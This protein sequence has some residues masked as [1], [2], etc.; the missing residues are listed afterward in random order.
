[1]KEAVTHSMKL[2]LVEDDPDA[3]V[4]LKYSLEQNGV[5]VTR[6]PDV[7][8][9]LKL[10][11]VNKYD[12]VVSDI[13]LPKLSGVDLLSRIRAMSPDFPVILLTAYDSLDT[14]IQAV[15]L[16]AQD[17]ILKPLGTIDD[18]LIPVA[19][20]VEMYRM[21][22][23]SKELER[24]LRDSEERFR[25]LVESSSDHIFMLNTDG[26]VM[27]SNNR[28]K[29]LPGSSQ[30][31]MENYSI[32]DIV[33]AENSEICKVHLRNVVMTGVPEIFVLRRVLS[34]EE[35]YY[36]NILYPIR[37]DNAVVAAGGISR[38]ITDIKKHEIELSRSRNEL[39][40]MGAMLVKISEKERREYAQDI[41]DQI[42]QNVTSLAVLLEL[43]R[44]QSG[45]SLSER[46][47][48]VIRKA[49]AQVEEIGKHVDSI[50]AL[51]KPVVID[52]YGLISALREHART[53]AEVQN[54]DVQVKGDDA[55]PR[56]PIDVEVAVFRIAQEAL[57]N[58]GKH[59]KA[60]HVLISL[61]EKKES[62]VL[63]VSD[64]GVGFAPGDVR[65]R[66]RKSWGLV[67]MRERAHSIGGTLD[68]ESVQGNGTRVVC[69]FS[70]AS[71]H[72]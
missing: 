45:G 54:L 4:M 56:L 55:M 27:F 70:R 13:R 16:G 59:A 3:S 35:R 1:M 18:L 9:A 52:D 53:F 8:E 22:L 21:K 72:K 34:G 43:L 60:K 39:R 10:F 6:V 36:Q 12:V 31:D 23:R 5:A 15:K 49:Q 58:I 65:E 26:I 61:E 30:P 46:T 64:D 67:I 24:Q 42:G 2:F 66:G 7:E 33:G 62:I 29:F 48:K 47:K 11:D 71:G 50:I 14:A 17:Y 63:T 51:M 20:A 41:H 57:N 44:E 25:S 19:R 37:A 40:E 68:I 38:D 32:N 28:L 69:A